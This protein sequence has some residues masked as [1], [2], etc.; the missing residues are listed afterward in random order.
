MGKPL[1][2][3]DTLAGT[4]SAP[5]SASSI[6]GNIWTFIAAALTMHF[7]IIPMRLAQSGRVFW[8]IP[9]ANTGSTSTI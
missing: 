6:W 7:P 9:G 2:D 5:P 4:L 8:A 3:W 1:G